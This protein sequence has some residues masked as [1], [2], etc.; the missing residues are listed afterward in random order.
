M[1]TS[2]RTFLVP[3]PLGR[4]RVLA[5]GV[6]LI[7]S[8]LLA[9]RSIP[10]ARRCRGAD[11]VT[12]SVVNTYSLQSFA[13]LLMRTVGA[14]RSRVPG[15]AVDVEVR[16]PLSTA[17]LLA[18]ETPLGSSTSI[19]RVPKPSSRH[20]DTGFALAGLVRQLDGV[21]A[22]DGDSPDE[23]QRAIVWCCQL[24]LRVYWSGAV[25]IQAAHVLHMKQG[26]S[27][28]GNGARDLLLVE[29]G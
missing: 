3:V 5:A 28:P 15:E 12:Q 11:F 27:G 2:A 22:L 16:C 18:T 23:R 6:F 24:T 17:L 1:P 26:N 9:G 14:G 20:R 7:S 10:I 29:W 21:A 19:S 4:G 8:L 13:E 25:V